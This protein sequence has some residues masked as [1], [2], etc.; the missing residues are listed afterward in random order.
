[1]LH[2]SLRQLEYIVAVGKA[3]S[4]SAAAEALNVS[5]PALSVA[6]ASVEHRVGEVLF[7]RRKGVAISLTAFGR[8]FLAEAERLLAEA[9]RLER[10]NGLA[11]RRQSRVAIGILDE[12]A[13]RWLA[14]ILALVRK[15]FPETEVRAVAL[16]FGALA[17]E[18]LSG[19]VDLGVTYD[20]GLD[21]SYRR[22]HLARAVP[23]IWVQPSDSLARRSE[24]SLA[25]IADRTLILSDQ[26]LSIQHML[27]LFRRI[28]VTPVV[29]HRAVSIEVLR[30]LAANGEG[31]GLSYTYPAGPVSSDGKPVSSVPINDPFAAEPIVLAS[32]SQLPEPLP[33]ISAAILQL[34]G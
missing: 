18:L 27:A 6:I 2:V 11:Q 31:T 14:P 26:A 16:S 3:G 19:Q 23:R 12:L 29:R 30:S 13:P 10:P 20:L 4:L 9:G 34:N 22:T 1:M 25:E 24:V 33:Q 21:A 32:L 5:Q 8:I 17:D 15:S 28:G 7:L